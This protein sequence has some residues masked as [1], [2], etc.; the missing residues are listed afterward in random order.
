MT[1]FVYS[2]YGLGGRT[3]SWAIKDYVC[4]GLKR[5]LPELVVRDTLGFTQWRTI[6]EQIK[7]QPSNTKSVVI[8]HSMGASSATYPTDEAH[9]DLVVC[10]DCAGQAPVGVAKNCGRLLDFWD[11][12]W[13]FVPKFRPW[14]Y[15][16]YGAILR[17]TQ[18][19]DGHVQ[20]PS[21]P[22]LFN[23][24]LQQVALLR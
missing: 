22:A 24:V 11:R 13:A 10:Y 12:A 21:D 16:G 23:I 20:Q 2:M 9:V 19:R 5:E 18:T 14:A 6:Q 8:G 4:A 15:P 3:F 7:N 17:Q 1:V